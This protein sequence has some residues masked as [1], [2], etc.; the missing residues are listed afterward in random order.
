MP[1][2]RKYYTYFIR[3]RPNRAGVITC[4]GINSTEYSLTLDENDVLFLL[5]IINNLNDLKNELDILDEQY[6]SINRQN[7]LT[8]EKDI[9]SDF[10][11]TDQGKKNTKEDSEFRKFLREQKKR[12]D[13]F[14][15]DGT[16]YGGRDF[17]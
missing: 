17:S 3:C 16:P 6:L 2:R 12:K 10:R 14:K 5:F 7:K 4:I 9:K 15:D 1:V 11:K 8:E 13:T